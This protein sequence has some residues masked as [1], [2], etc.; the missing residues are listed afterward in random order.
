MADAKTKIKVQRDLTIDENELLKDQQSIFTQIGKIIEKNNKSSSKMFSSMKDY[1][2]DIQKESDLLEKINKTKNLNRD[3]TK[4]IKDLE[5]KSEIAHESYLDLRK[6]GGTV[7]ANFY[8]REEASL[9]RQIKS[10]KEIQSLNKIALKDLKETDDLKKAIGSFFHTN[11]LNALGFSKLTSGLQNSIQQIVVAHGNNKKQATNI[12]N[13]LNKWELPLIGTIFLL[14]KI[15]GLFGELDKSAFEARKEMGMMRDIH[16]ILRNQSE[17]LFRE[18]A[19]IGLTTENIYKSQKAVSNELGSTLSATKDIVLQAGL[20]ATHFG[21]SEDTTVRML[22]TLG[23]VGRTT[24]E[25]QIKMS[26]FAMALSNAAG[27]PLPQV[28]DDIAK[29]SEMTLIMMSKTPLQLIKAAVEARRMGTTLDKMTSSSRKILNFTES[30]EAEMEASVLLGRPLNLQLARQLAYSGKIVESNREIL[31]LT[32]QFNFDHMDPFQAEAFAA[33]TGKTVVE[34]KSMIQANRENEEIKRKSLSDKSIAKQLK[35]LNELKESTEAIAKAR[36]EDA[37]SI[38]KSQSNQTR[39]NSISN[40]WKRIIME[41]STVFLPIID[42]FLKGVAWILSSKI[43]MFTLKWGSLLMIAATTLKVIGLTSGLISKNW[44]GIVMSAETWILK[45]VRSIP[46]L[47]NIGSKSLQVFSKIGPLMGRV[48]PAIWTGITTIGSR[49]LSLL[50]PITKI[51]AAFVAGWS[52]GKLLNKI[53]FVQK[54]AEFFFDTMFAGWDMI[55]YYSEKVITGIW[56]GIKSAG[57]FIFDVLKAPFVE[58]WKFLSDTFLGH[59]PSKLGLLIVDGIKA[60]GSMIF[61]SIVD[62]FKKAWDYVSTLF[63]HKI[64]PSVT[65][66]I[67]EQKLAN[68]AIPVDKDVQSYKT[69][70]AVSFNESTDLVDNKKQ[71]ASDVISQSLLNEIKGLREDLLSGKIAVNLDGQLVSTTMNRGNKFRGNY[72]AIQG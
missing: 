1:L 10:L 61:S 27:V 60:V 62:P 43:V 52:I 45:L 50:N 19:H 67:V 51:A 6:I 57:S 34:L 36:G 41:I 69:L 59:S 38:L 49:I 47:T 14:G 22:K 7:G 44:F 29:S 64:Q 68:V 26:G 2:A 11:L 53:G 20:M 24:A 42:G 55:K 3:I 8:R 13:V 15:I 54:A 18:Y 31:K 23:Q 30:M 39:M 33:A 46:L 28:M 25:A 5:I 56:T 35:E 63:G 71:N 65:R 70:D 37:N 4:E 12:L 40:S 17:D 72:G 58:V 9:E 16:S 32:K 66:P 48:L 21:I